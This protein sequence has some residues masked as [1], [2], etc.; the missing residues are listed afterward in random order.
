MRCCQGET[1][2]MLD[3]RVLAW[4]CGVC[5]AFARGMLLSL[6]CMHYLPCESD[7]LS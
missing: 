5:C 1:V 7:M 6:L 3:V 2:L 4:T